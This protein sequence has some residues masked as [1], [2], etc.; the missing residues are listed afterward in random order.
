MTNR[1]TERRLRA[2]EK[3]MGVTGN[4][5]EHL[6]DLDLFVAIGMVA[7]HLASD[8]NVDAAAD[9]ARYDLEEATA[10]AFY[11]R[12]DVAGT[13]RLTL[14]PGVRWPYLRAKARWQ[15]TNYGQGEPR[16]AASEAEALTRKAIDLALNGDP[17]A[18]RLCLERILPPRK[19]RPVDIVLPPLSGQCCTARCRGGRRDRTG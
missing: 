15:E 16:S 2:V 3:R 4:S 18:L 17:M 11:E 13:C 8:G 5:L 10:R 19:E 6:S 1:A 9:L 12:P 7:E 14:E